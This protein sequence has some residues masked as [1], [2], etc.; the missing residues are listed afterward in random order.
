[1]INGIS[2]ICY[3]VFEIERPLETSFIL[4]LYEVR[5]EEYGPDKSG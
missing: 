5:N 1:M 4:K 3:N 2:G